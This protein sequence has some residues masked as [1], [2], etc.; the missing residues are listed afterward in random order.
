MPS[1]PHAWG[2]VS[3]L[4]NCPPTTKA[5]WSSKLQKVAID[6]EVDGFH[7]GW[8]AK[9]NGCHMLWSRGLALSVTYASI[10]HTLYYPFAIGMLREFPNIGLLVISPTAI[11]VHLLCCSTR[12]TSCS[13]SNVCKGSNFLAFN[14]NSPQSLK[15]ASL[16]NPYP[17]SQ[18]VWDSVINMLQFQT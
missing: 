6:S 14:T 8:H 1:S 4:A 7:V 5:I 13:N 17:D 10:V 15:L 9:G 3:F 11:L 18:Y 16:Q 12:Y 2:K